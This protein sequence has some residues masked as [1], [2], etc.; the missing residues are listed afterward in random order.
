MK[1]FRKHGIDLHVTEP[2][3]HNQSKVEGVIREMRKKL[4]CVIL[5]K[6]VTRRL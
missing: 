1:E 3:R 2:D 5:R 4:F 6:K